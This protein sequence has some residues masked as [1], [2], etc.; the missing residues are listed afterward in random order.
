MSMLDFLK[1]NSKSYI[2][3]FEKIGYNYTSYQ[4][5]TFPLR[6]QKLPY[7]LDELEPFISKQTMYYHYNKHYKGYINKLNNLIENSKL[8]TNTL[9][10]SDLLS[11]KVAKKYPDIYNN[12][13]QVWNH[14]FY[15]NCLSPYRKSMSLQLRFLI[16]DNFGSYEQFKEEFLQKAKNHFGSGWIWLVKNL[17]TNKLEIITTKDAYNPLTFGKLVPVLVLD[18]WEHAYYIDSKNN[19]DVYIDNWFEIINWGFVEKN[20]IMSKK[21]K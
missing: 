21:F 8:N 19:K 12:A 6:F 14:T 13:A 7:E 18:M 4:F 2:S 9:R 16:H 17:H 20:I 1:N 5:M 11:E 10:L 3:Q 15:W